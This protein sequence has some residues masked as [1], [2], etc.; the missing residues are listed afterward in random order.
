MTLSPRRVCRLRNR[1]PAMSLVHEIDYGTPKSKATKTV[2]LTIDGVSVTVPEGTS[3][4]RAAMEMGTQIPKLCATDMVDAFGSCRLCL[5]EIE[6]RA[7]TPASC[8][9]PVAEGMAVRTHTDRL[10]RLRK[11]VMELYIS[12]HPLDCLTCSANGDC[13]LQDMAGAVGLRD[14]RYGYNGDNHVFAKSDGAANPSWLPKDDS[15]PYFTYDPSKCIVCSRC[16]R[17]CEE[18][19]GTFALTISGRGF[20]SVVSPGMEESFLNSEC[21]YCGACWQGGLTGTLHEQAV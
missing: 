18:V 6:G 10:K 8:T 16:V 14:V 3:I 4:M 11:G 2:T 12:D 9:T 1:R 21:V 5:V 19:Q 13:E 7:G 17:A 15:N 20:G